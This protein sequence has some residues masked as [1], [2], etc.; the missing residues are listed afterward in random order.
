MRHHRFGKR[1]RENLIGVDPALAALCYRALYLS[2]HDFAITEGLRGMERQKSLVAAGKSTT[3]HSYHL[4]G[5]AVDFA[6]FIGGAVTWE[7]GFYNDVAKAFKHA[8]DEFGLAITW[9]G[10]W[11][12]F[13]DG[14]HIQLEG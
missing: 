11:T 3:M 10:D 6:V 7:L 2:P 4:R 9:G 13:V 14:P 1:S 12:S 8:A 5:A